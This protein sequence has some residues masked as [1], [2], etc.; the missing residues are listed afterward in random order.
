MFSRICLAVLSICFMTCSNQAQNSEHAAISKSFSNWW[1]DGKAEI[2]SYALSQARYGEVHEGKAIIIF[3]TEDFSK[4]KQVKL[5]DP[6]LH[7]NDA[8][9]VLKMNHTRKFNTG[10][11][12]YS[13]MTSAFTATQYAKYPFMVKATTTSQEWCGHTFLQFN[14][15]RDRAY[16]VQSNS[17][18]ET[19]GDHKTEVEASLFEDQLWSMIRIDPTSLPIGEVALIPSQIYLRLRH[20][21]IENRRA[22]VKILDR[23]G[24]F[25]ESVYSV[26]YT[27]IDRSLS[28]YFEKQFPHKITGWK[29]KYKS[30]FGPNAKI[31]ETQAYQIKRIRTDYW[32][33]NSSADFGLYEDLFDLED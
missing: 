1:H 17:Y 32:T 12:P 13:M 15:L 7:R 8:L 29:E 11:Y 16:T 2:T 19:E 33:K 28:I 26:N 3:V 27:D 18:F 31:I 25:R 4:S 14:K 22:T 30:G 10:I 24:H 21:P 5:D 23:P 6:S 20:V 9:P